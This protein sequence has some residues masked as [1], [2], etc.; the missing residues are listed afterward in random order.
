MRYLK[1]AR[2]E[3]LKRDPVFLA[4]KKVGV[5]QYEDSDSEPGIGVSTPA[6][7]PANGR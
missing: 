3:C 4:L 1:G 2:N 7:L 6:R 5:R